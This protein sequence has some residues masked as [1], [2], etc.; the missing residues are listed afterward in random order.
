MG[1]GPQVV[2]M[3]KVVWVQHP[4]S[5]FGSNVSAI[6]QFS[7]YGW[8]FFRIAYRVVHIPSIVSF[9]GDTPWA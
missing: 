5:V 6:G 3:P 9:I 7:G 2:S 1:R 4:I 8:R